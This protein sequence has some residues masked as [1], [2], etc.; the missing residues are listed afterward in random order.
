MGCLIIKGDIMGEIFYKLTTPQ[1]SILLTEMFYKNTSINHICGTATIKNKL[2]FDLLKKAICILIEN[3]DSFHLKF[4]LNNNEMVQSLGEAN[5][6]NIEIVDVSSLEEVA[7]LEKRS[8]DYNFS[9][10]DSVLYKF[11]IFRLP[12][13][14]GGF[15]AD[16][17][18]ILSDSWTLG[19]I[20][21]E[22]VRIYSCLLKGEEV[23]KCENFSYL[24]YINDEKEYMKSNKFE[25]DKAYWKEV[26]KT[27][28]EQASIP[29]TLKSSNSSFSC[30][31]NRRSFEID[32]ATLDKINAWCKEFH[33]SV[34]NFFMAVYSVYIARVSNLT[35]FVIGTPILNRSNFNQK[36]TTGMF[37]NTAPLRINIDNN[38]SFSSF[39]SNIAKDSLAM[40]RHQKYHYQTILEDL[41]TD[42]AALPNLYNILISFQ[43]TRAVAEGDISYETRWNFNGNVA[44]DINIHL[45]DLNDEGMLNIA[46]DYK[47]SKYNNKDIEA[48]HNRVLHIIN[49]I[50]AKPD[51]CL[52]DILVVTSSEKYNILYN[53]NNTDV[54]YDFNKNIH[55]LFEEQVCKTPDKIAIVCNDE[56][57]TYKELN[58]KAN[59]LSR[60]LVNSGV[61]PGDIVGI[62]LPRS[63]DMI[64]GLIG[65]LKAGAAY[66]PIDPDY[67]SDRITYMLDNS[68]THTVLV[69]DST[70]SI[71]SEDYNRINLSCNLDSTLSCDNLNLDVPSSSLMYLIYTSGSTGKPKGVMLTHRNINNFILGTTNVI[72][73][74]QD[75]VMVSLTTICFDIFVLEIWAS[76]TKGLCVVIAN[77]TE[78]KDVACFNA[79]CLKYNVNML[80]TTPSRLSAFLDNS[81]ELNY[82]SNLTDILVGGEP[83]PEVLLKKLK[84]LSNAKIY[85]MYGPTETAV[86]ST[87]KDLSNSDTITIG[88]PIANTTCYV[89]DENKNL[90]PT[91]I[92]GELYIG[93]DGVSKGYLNREE[94]TKEKFVTS[95]FD[96][97]SLIYNT[98][99]LAY[100]TDDGELVHLGRTDF[101]VKI[102]GYRVEL[103]EIENIISSFPGINICVV[104]CH[105]VGVKQVLCAYYTCNSSVDVSKVKNFVLQKLPT[106]M[107]PAHFIQVDKMPYTPNG[108]IDRKAF[109]FD[110]NYQNEE[111]VMPCDDIEK[112]LYDIIVSIRHID[113]FSMTDNLFSIG[114]DSI[115][116]MNLSVKI[117]NVFGIEISVK[118][119]YEIDSILDLANLI[120]NNNTLSLTISKAAPKKSYP[121]SCAQSRIYYA[122]KMSDNSTIYNIPGGMLVDS[123]LDVNKIE[124]AFKKLIKLHSSFRTCFKF[125]DDQPIQVVLDNVDFNVEVNNSKEADLRDIIDSFPSAF[126]L[127]NAPLLRV[128]VHFLDNKKTLILIDSHHIIVDG[129]SL[130]ILIRDFCKLYNN[131]EIEKSNLEYVDYAVWENDFINSDAIT[132]YENY[133]VNNFKNSEIPVINLP[134]DYTVSATPSY[135]GDRIS[136]KLS[137]TI[138]ENFEKIAKQYNCSSYMVFLAVFYVLL[139]KYTSQDNI[140]VGSPIANRFSS[141]LQNIIGMFVNNIALNGHI[142]ST[143]TFSE[144]LEDVKTMVLNAMKNQAYPYDLLVKK[145]DLGTSNLF[146]VMFTYQNT[147]KE[148]INLGDNSFSV[149]E[150]NTHTSKFNL[151]FEIVPF[152]CV[153]NLEFRTDLFKKETVSRM[154]N[155]YINLLNNVSNYMDTKISDISMLSDDERNMIL[156]DFNDTKMDYPKDKTIAELFEEQVKYTP[157]KIA[158]VFENESLTYRELNEK[159]NALAWYLISLGAKEHDIIGICMNRSLELL[160]SMLS[161]LKLGAAYLPIDPTYPKSRI[162]YIIKDSNI[163]TILSKSDLSDTYPNIRFVNVNLDNSN[164]YI[165]NSKLNINHKFSSDNLAYLIYTSGSTGN[166]K[167]VMLSNKNVNNFIFGTC[168]K[169]SFKNYSNI[170]SVTTMCFDIFVLESLLPLELGLTIILANETE[171]NIAPSLN[172]LCIENNVQ[173]LQTTPSRMSLLMS[174]YNSLEYLKNLKCIMLGGEP[175]PETLLIELKKYTNAS[176]FNMYGPTE[177][178]VWSTIKDL[179]N[180]NN[181]TIG[182]PISNTSCYILDNNLNPTPIG[183]IGNLYIGGDGVSKGYFNRAA[184]TNDKFIN[185]PFISNEIIYNT[186]DLAAWTSGGEINCLG[187]SDFQVKINGLRIELG[188]IEKRILSYPSMFKVVVTVKKDN[189]NRQLLCAYFVANSRISSSDLKNFLAKYLPA[190]M[191]PTYLLQL[192]D[193]PFTPNGKIDRN[194]LPLPKVNISKT[195]VTPETSTEKILTNIVEELLGI[196]PI[197]ITDNFFDIGGDSILA[198]KLQTKLLNQNMNISYSD[199]YRYNTIKE[200]ALKLDTISSS[201]AIYDDTYDFKNIDKILSN[202]NINNLNNI[203][204]SD[205]GNVLLTGCTGF[206]GIHILGYLIENTNSTVYC[207]IRKDPSTSINDKLLSKLHYYFG[208]KYDNLIGNRIVVVK[209][210]ITYPDLGISEK[211]LSEIFTQISCVINSAA[212]VKHYGYYSDFEDINVNSVKYL[213]YFCKKFNKKFVQISTIS[214]SGNTLTDLAISNNKFDTIKY[215]D[216]SSLNI[217]QDLSNVYVRSKYEAEKYILEEIYSSNLD[218]LILRIGNITNRSYD[219]KFQP[220]ANDNAFMHRIDALLELRVLPKYILDDYIEFSPV[221]LVAQAVIKSIQYHNKSI[222]VLHIYNHNHVFIRDFIHLLPFNVDIVSTDEFKSS[223]VKSINTN[224]KLVYITNDLDKDYNLIYSSNIKIR[225]NLSVEFFNKINFNWINIDK[226]YINLMLNEFYKEG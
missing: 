208:N 200:M 43:V 89:L 77:E 128:S 145:L 66:L 207:L 119:M 6:D 138:F 215:F 139:Y 212:I 213:T 174:D 132:D 75:K 55:K 19:I 88:K 44:D 127:E 168:N 140:I 146:D 193:F 72:D 180:T 12:D 191:I 63:L 28:P 86:W 160:V 106:Y 98:N 16:V 93:G 226:N 54:E 137:N 94:L 33:V 166:P 20:A 217:G 124:N 190:Y 225:N 121:L 49:Q 47:L 223:L 3:N 192:D 14:S 167:G 188:E 118:S 40:L 122:T 34:F 76:L 203:F 80:Q 73:F 130:N 126:D 150:A 157:D 198:L 133:W 56:K 135:S 221:D 38:A 211:I 46:Y 185:N 83:L 84:Q 224:P 131:I 176:I 11:T 41:R 161:I 101:Q 111:L 95:P 220:N 68:K 129:S 29:A 113:K 53:F 82:L 45:Y 57:L 144:F 104:V 170:V 59:R 201:N 37:I 154:L 209:S 155:H 10:E 163:D 32:H 26:F 87:I 141:D 67:P 115:D 27:V 194:A 4:N 177:T 48:V 169:I 50:L 159:A 158:V 206:L 218:A 164:I 107:V 99:D 109:K 79:L 1:K 13:G 92:P 105:K 156:Y 148:N 30:K 183:M 147:A 165:N 173:M 71:L 162:E 21:K 8:I 184:L 149:I 39:V 125:I 17:H 90:L 25:V 117:Y 182:K 219:G 74:S 42:N 78:Q 136:M 103:G 189:L 151:S 179:T 108:K 100:F 15:I 178:T 172:K 110:D 96:T 70:Y 216:E 202:N 152:S 36:N 62:M 214:V 58:E 22:V 97:N 23:V 114:M 222:N 153:I 171:Q 81:D 205:I 210:D 91:Y 69:N 85:N 24:A 186:G 123:I 199:I 51:I 134:Y 52:K 102:R 142:D 60:Y 18:H 204:P 196:S 195:I 181:I 35:D 65:I 116:I 64:I 175:F 197:S 143:K 31:A 120:K 61:N 5:L 2:D 7:N 187:R 112:K 9:I